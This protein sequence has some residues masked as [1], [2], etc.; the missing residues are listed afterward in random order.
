LSEEVDNAFLVLERTSNKEQASRADGRAVVGVALGIDDDV[1][2]A[3]FVFEGEEM[4]AF[5]GRRG[6]VDNE[7]TGN[8]DV[9]AV[10]LVGEVFAAEDMVLLEV[11]AIEGHDMVAGGKAEDGLFGEHG[12]GGGKGRQGNSG[13]RNG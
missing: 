11:G 3:V 1:D 13:G 6:L 8:A 4:E 9:A 12:S 2:Q 7:E 10:G 5:G